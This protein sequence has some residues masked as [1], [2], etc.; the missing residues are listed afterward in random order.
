[1]LHLRKRDSEDEWNEIVEDLQFRTCDSRRK[2]K[3][4]VGIK[5]NEL[6]GI[7]PIHPYSAYILKHIS[8]SFNSNQRSMFN[9]IK[10]RIED[11]DIKTFQWFID[12]VGPESE[13]PFLSVDF[14][15]SYFYESDRDALTPNI[16][17][18]LD[19]YSRLAGTLDNTEKGFLKLYCYC[20]H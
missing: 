4:K 6:R 2:I 11:S 18:I 10:N 5:D 17:L 20:K 7:L 15:W 1:M 16:R 9:F 3:N 14:L 12:N 19:N 13:N 8:A